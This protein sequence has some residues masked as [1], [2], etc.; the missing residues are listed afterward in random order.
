M[1]KVFCF[2]KQWKQVFTPH[3]SL[4]VLLLFSLILTALGTSS[5]SVTPKVSA[6][7][8]HTIA[9]KSDGTVWTWGYNSQGQLGDRTYTN[10]SSPVQVSKLSGLSNVIAIAGGEGHTL[11]L[12]SDETVW[13][14][15]GNWSGQLGNNTYTDRNIPTQV[16]GLTDISAI[17][18]GYNHSLVLKSDGT[19]WAWGGG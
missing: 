16:S 12:K 7:S 18:C 17:A 3:V 9:L 13:A 15:G 8:A 1:K 11:A 5:A 2:F 14:W 4:Y 19:V 6:G 10:R